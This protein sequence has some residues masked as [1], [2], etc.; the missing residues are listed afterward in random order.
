MKTVPLLF[1]HDHTQVLGTVTFDEWS[2]DIAL[3]EIMVIDPA[4]ILKEYHFDEKGDRHLDKIEIVELSLI[5]Q[6]V[7]D[8]A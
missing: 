5:P 7:I 6:K 1:A 3:R 8:A 4:Y 2:L